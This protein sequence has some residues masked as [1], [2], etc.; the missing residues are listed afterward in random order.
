MIIVARINLRLEH[1]PLPILAQNTWCQ[2]LLVWCQHNI[3]WISSLVTGLSKILYSKAKS[4]WC[5]ALL[6]IIHSCDTKCKRWSPPWFECQSYRRLRGT[7]LSLSRPMNIK[8]NE[9]IRKSKDK[10]V[11]NVFATSNP[12]HTYFTSK[13]SKIPKKG[14]GG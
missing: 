10:V 11:P 8:T 12:P 7:K 4:I 14:E 1:G 5:C 6:K 2:V 9:V 13:T 3:V